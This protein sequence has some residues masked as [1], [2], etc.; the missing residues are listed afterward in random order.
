[1]PD[2]DVDADPNSGRPDERKEWYDRI[3]YVRGGKPM[4]FCWNTPR[5]QA[6]TNSLTVEN[7]PGEN[8]AIDNHGETVDRF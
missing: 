7:V 2:I 6:R 5:Q 4:P 1:V 8:P 3:N